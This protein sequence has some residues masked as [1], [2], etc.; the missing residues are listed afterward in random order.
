MSKSIEVYGIKNCDTV[1]KS[2][3][4]LA[5]KL[6]DKQFEI[7]FHDFKKEVLTED[8]VNQW[9]QQIDSSIL[10]NRKGTTWRKLDDS[11]KNLTEQSDMVKLIISNPSII[12][13]PV[14]LFNNNWSVAFNPDEWQKRF[15]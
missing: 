7:N 14:V 5:E 9:F 13:R 12:K 1:K 3:K 4:W 15:I 11:Q 6:P 2:L 10:I 8:L